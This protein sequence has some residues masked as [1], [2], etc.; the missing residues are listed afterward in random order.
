[1]QRRLLDEVDKVDVL[2][3]LE[4]CTDLQRFLSVAGGVIGLA[5]LA[6]GALRQAVVPTFIAADV[7]PQ[8]GIL[9][10][11]AF[12]TG[13]VDARVRASPSHAQ[14]TGRGDPRALFPAGTDARPHRRRVHELGGQAHRLGESAPAARLT[15]QQLQ[16][17]LLILAPLLSAVIT[18]VLPTLL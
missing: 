2:A 10:Y 1:V 8:E 4:A 5:V 14:A 18:A 7:F 17:S 6:A 16:A 3:A 12:F 15:A 13:F 9:L 11:G